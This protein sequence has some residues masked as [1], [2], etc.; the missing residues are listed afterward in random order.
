[1]EIRQIRC[2]L[3]VAET[4]NFRRAAERLNIS[5]P[6]VTVAIQ[7]LEAEIGCSLFIRNKQNV[8]LSSAGVAFRRTAHELMER[9]A[10]GVQQV[11]ALNK[12]TVSSIRIGFLV[13][14]AWGLLPSALENFRRSYADVEIKLEPHDFKDL[15]LAM[16][17]GRCDLYLGSYVPPDEKWATRKLQKLDVITLIPPQHRLAVTAAPIS[18][19]DLKGETLLLPLSNYS[20]TLSAELLQ[21]CMERGGFRPKFIEDLDPPSLVIFALSSLGIGLFP[22]PPMAGLFNQFCV[23][24]FKES[25]PSIQTG[26]AWRRDREDP[27]LRALVGEIVKAAK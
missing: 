21:F 25:G 5:Q 12:G 6:P 23:R 7:K 3:A 18:I 24:P 10:H 16:E 27:A 2:F 20:R 22:Q 11:R 26:L 19:K 1:M 9:L 17:E 14:A 4:L 13:S 15:F 8:R